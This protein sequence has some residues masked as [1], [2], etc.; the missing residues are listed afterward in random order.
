MK[1]FLTPQQV[2]LYKRLHRKEHDRRLADRIKIILAFNQG[3]SAAEIAAMLLIDEETPR[4]YLDVFIADGLKKLL[5]LNHKGSESILSDDQ[6]SFLK[7][8]LSQ[9]IY[10]SSKEIAL[11]IQNEYKV[12]IS[13]SGCRAILKSLDFVYRKPK[14]I[15]G[16]VNEQKQ[17]D[18]IERYNELKK[19]LSDSD[20]IYFI[21]GVHPTHNVKPAFGWIL[22]SD[23]KTVR[24][25][26]GRQ[27][28][29][30]NGALCLNKKEILIQ[31]SKT[32]NAQS[33]I[34]LFEIILSKNQ[35][36]KNIF[37]ISDNAR[38]YKCKLLNEWLEKNQ[39]IKMVYL[40]PYS[41][42]L[43]LIERVWRHMHKKVTYNKYYEKYL[44]FREHILKFFLE[45][46]NN[47]E[48]VEKLLNDKFQIIGNTA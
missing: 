11:Y 35:D 18:F 36:A 29:N 43:N 32:I 22:K 3:Y 23:K 42:N 4:R 38:Y 7:I 26:T 14:L 13:T 30:I 20:K 9:H 48:E 12:K 25:N 2:S 10:L 44:L 1:N 24:S 5:S 28:I 19:A 41:P 47:W 27:R 40:P 16:Q 34:S 33:T 6:K 37:I 31:E 21:D 46:Q 15:P 39:I 45:F 8:H 17:R